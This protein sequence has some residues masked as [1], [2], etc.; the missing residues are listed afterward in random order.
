MQAASPSSLVVV[1]SYALELDKTTM[2]ELGRYRQKNE[3]K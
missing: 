1:N 2:L 3:S